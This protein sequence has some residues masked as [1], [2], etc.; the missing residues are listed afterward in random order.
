M[1]GDQ[2]RAAISDGC[3]RGQLDLQELWFRYISLGGD[4]T[5]LELEAYLLGLMPLDDHQYDILALA[6]NERLAELD[7]ARDV[8]YGRDRLPCRRRPAGPGD[9]PGG[10]PGAPG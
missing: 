3:R 10:A 2:G 9:Q 1:T 5:P 8:P 6:L 7:L 4:A